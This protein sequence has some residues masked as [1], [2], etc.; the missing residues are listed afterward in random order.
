MALHYDCRRIKMVNCS[1]ALHGV[2]LDNT[3][4]RSTAAKKCLPAHLVA[5]REKLINSGKIK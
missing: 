1:G 5:T 3:P 2:G 4:A